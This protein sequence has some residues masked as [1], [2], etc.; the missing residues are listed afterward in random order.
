MKIFVIGTPKSGKTRF[1][2]KIIK[3]KSEL[4]FVNLDNLPKKYI[5]KT[6]LALGRISD[7]RVDIMFSSHVLE[8]EY[9]NKDK[10][11]I[12]S[13]GPLYSYSHFVAKAKFMSEEKAMEALWPAALLGRIV[14]DS[15]W[16]DKAYY[17]PYK[18]KDEYTILLDKA[19]RQS[20]LDLKISKEI[21]KV[22]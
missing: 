11:Y 17:L 10:N 4:D 20:I 14:R 21:E 13:S 12:V 16:Y 8:Q 3:E 18:G 5:K 22:E 15:F 19:I 7:Y 9:R 2:N 6:G 1:V